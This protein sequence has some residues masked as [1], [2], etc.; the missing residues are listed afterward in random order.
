MRPL[1]V[2]AANSPRV[3]SAKR[4]VARVL[5][6]SNIDLNA[7]PSM[8]KFAEVDE[9]SMAS[10]SHPAGPLSV[11]VGP[12]VSRADAARARSGCVAAISS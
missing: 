4:P 5:D 12:E 6:Y 3:S 9:A 1:G 11:L 7:P 8:D 2:H 10:G